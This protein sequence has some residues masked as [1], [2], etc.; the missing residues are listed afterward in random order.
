VR[1]P[2]FYLPAGSLLLI[3]WLADRLIGKF[4]GAQNSLWIATTITSCLKGENVSLDP[5]NVTAPLSCD[6]LTQNVFRNIWNF[7]LTEIGQL[8]VL[9]KPLFLLSAA[10]I[11]GVISQWRA[12]GTIPQF[13]LLIFLLTFGATTLN[14][15]LGLNFRLMTPALPYLIIGAVAV[16]DHSISKVKVRV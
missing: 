6:Q 16:I 13:C 8:A 9:D 10:I 4:L 3:T 11:I 7:V 14:A 15:T 1:K 12:I 2:I 5:G